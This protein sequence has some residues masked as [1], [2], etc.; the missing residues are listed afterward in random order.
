ME[1]ERRKKELWAHHVRNG[2]CNSRLRHPKR[3]FRRNHS[4]HKNTEYRFSVRYLRRS[5][6]ALADKEKALHLAHL[7]TCVQ[8]HTHSVS[9]W[10]FSVVRFVQHKSTET[11]MKNNSLAGTRRVSQAYDNEVRATRRKEREKERKKKKMWVHHVCKRE[12][13]RRLRHPKRFFGKNLFYF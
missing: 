11:K 8:I 9:Q 1:S 4:C 5:R 2:E 3:F 10:N 7:H 12:C 13:R 6:D